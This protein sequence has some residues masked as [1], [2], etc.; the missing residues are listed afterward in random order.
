MAEF[1]ESRFILCEGMDD[2]CF[3]EALIREHHLP[4]FQI[5]HAAEFNGRGIGESSTGGKDGFKTALDRVDV[6]SGFDNLKAIL[7]V[8]D[9]D[10]PKSLKKLRQSLKGIGSV[11]QSV[12]EVGTIYGKPLAVFLIPSATECGDLETFCLPEIHKVWPRSPRCVED[13]LTNTGA[14][15]WTKQSSINKARA[16]AAVVGFYQPD[17]YMGIGYLFR[18]GQLSVKN[19]RFDALVDFLRKFD[20]FAGI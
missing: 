11:P 2:K 18:K 19:Q 4:S 5:C 13:F 7:I 8:T 3:L 10:E 17:P 15:N 20:T 16:R 6:L 9:N 12:T 1:T 14:L